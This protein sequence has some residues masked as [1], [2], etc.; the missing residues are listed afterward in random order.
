MK[1]LYLDCSMGAAGDMLTAALLELLPEP[2][3]FIAQ[4][5]ALGIPGV[6]MKREPSVK[7]GITGTH[8]SVTVNGEEEKSEDVGLNE[9]VHGHEHSHDHGH[10]HDH[11]HHHHS[12]LHDIEHIVMDHLPLPDKVREDVMA[13]YRLIAEA[14][15]AVHGVPVP[16]IHFHEVG[17]LDAVAD[18]TAVC[19]LMDKLA[20]AQVVASPVHVGC[21]QVRCAHGVLPVPAPAT[22]HILRGV[23]IYGGQIRGE[24]CTPTGAALLKHFVHRFGDMP[25]MR[26]TA[27]GYGM[28]TKDFEAVSCVR[29]MLGDVDS[30]GDEVF[31][32]M[33]NVD[34]MTAEAVG[35]AMEQLFDAGALDVFTTPAGMKKSR[36]GLLF[37]VLCRDADRDAVVKTMFK[38][39]T[40]LGIR[41]AR[42]RRYVLDR[43]VDT[44][45][46]PYGAVRRKTSS[47]YGVE[48]EKYEWEDLSRVA[49]EN[50]VSLSEAVSLLESRRD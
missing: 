3:E 30:A 49:R 35:F 50:G 23:P 4:M 33:C 42:L 28:G 12:G 6:H 22:A 27:I 29:A 15:S 24:L 9:H 2:D 39:T 32:L 1:T 37:H 41:E 13:V 43:R 25:P 26:T 7:C 8:V 40:T 31:E 17:T 21:G 47:G 10:H 45:D 18:I 5:N 20:P 34:D 48:R 44:L 19:L 36:P 11:H 14:E 16:D 38:H 46:T